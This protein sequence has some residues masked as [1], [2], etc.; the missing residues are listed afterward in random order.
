MGIHTQC[1]LVKVPAIRTRPQPGGPALVRGWGL[2]ERGC[3][4]NPPVKRPPE[5]VCPKLRPVEAPS[6]RPSPGVVEI[7]SCDSPEAGSRQVVESAGF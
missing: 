1:S 4:R 3:G 6:C 5:V 7:R 2:N